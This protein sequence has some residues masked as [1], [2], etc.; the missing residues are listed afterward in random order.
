MS[1]TDASQFRSSS[2]SGL[3][4]IVLF[5]K[6]DSGKTSI[7]QSLIDS[8]SLTRNDRGPNVGICDLG[9]SG[10][11]IVVDT[12][13]LNTAVEL[14]DSEMKT[15]YNIV[16]RA[17]VA[18]YII[19]IR[20][21]D[22]QTYERDLAWMKRNR[23]AHLL[24][25][26]KCDIAYAG[27]IA[28]FK[29]EF[30]HALFLSAHA[31]DALALLRA[32]LAEMIHRQLRQEPPLIPDNLVKTGDY[33]ILVVPDSDKK[34]IRD[35]QAMIIE[36]L[37]RGVRCVICCESELAM[38]LD[39]LPHVELVVAYARTFDKLREIVPDHV[40]LTSYAIL[41][42]RQKGDIQVFAD[43]AR[44][45]ST[46]T[47][48][49]R[50]LIA[51]GCHCGTTHRDIGHVQ[52]PRILREMTG[53]NLHI[54]Y[55]YGLDLPEDISQYDLVI[56]CGACSLSRRAL[57]AHMG[58]CRDAGVPIANFGTLLAE[59]AGILDRCLDDLPPETQK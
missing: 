30:P 40:R 28:R 42:G 15:T 38:T 18:V 57:Q 44:A 12:A 17:D 45:V 22:R 26:N 9:K 2:L 24:V 19:D 50:V 48:Q 36:F 52:I 10:P 20:A 23:I 6:K 34:A 43:G 5:G 31:P 25:F 56:H 53:E 59:V 49:S 51:E 7:F 3:R 21:F 1:I 16:R 58:I 4:H 37:Q 47:E 54:D 39:D 32:R 41:Y 13:S 29:M 27:D 55:C 11:V 33:V 8:P 46:L 35:P 14:D